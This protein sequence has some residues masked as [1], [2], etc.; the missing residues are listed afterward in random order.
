MWLREQGCEW[1]A[2]V[3]SSAICGE[4]SEVLRWVRKN[5]GDAPQYLNSDV[6]NAAANRGHL[7]IL[8]L[9]R[10]FNGP[11]IGPLPASST[12]H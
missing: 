3:L 4:N 10:Y 8:K 6:A 7:D 2:A 9:A 12:P 1:S 11:N 5:G